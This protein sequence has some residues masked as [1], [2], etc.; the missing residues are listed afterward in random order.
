M[1]LGNLEVTRSFPGYTRVV[2]TYVGKWLRGFKDRNGGRSKRAVASKAK[3]VPNVDRSA[4]TNP[5]T[6]NEESSERSFIQPGD[7]TP[8]NV[9]V[10]DINDLSS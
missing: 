10:N 8:E 9:E 6:E 1:S 4:T 3:E 7:E 2:K 5:E